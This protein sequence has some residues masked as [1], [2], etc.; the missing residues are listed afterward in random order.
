MWWWRALRSTARGRVDAENETEPAG[1]R[2]DVV[3][4]VRLALFLL[5][6]TSAL[7]GSESPTAYY[8]VE[9]V[10]D[11][12]GVVPKCNGL[13]FLP[14]GR[15][16]AAF[17]HG[18]ICF[19][20]PLSRKWTRYAEGLHTPMGVLAVSVKEI[21]VSQRPELTRLRDTDGDGV[22]DLYECVSDRWELSGN[23]HEFAYG[24]VADGKGGFYVALGS[25]SGE[26]VSRYEMRGH[27]DPAGRLFPGSQPK[28]SMYSFVAYRGWVV[29][30]GPDGGLTPIACGFRQPNGIV[31]DPQGRL[32]VTDNQGD[33]VGTS[34]LH[35]VQAGGFY[36]HPAGLCWEGDW[37]GPPTLE[38]LDRRRREG[39]VLFPHAI[40]A[41]SPGQ[42]AFDTTGGKF[43]PY[44]GQM[45][46]TEFNI[47]RV[48]RVMMEEVGGELQG[49]TAPFYDGPPLRAGCARLAFAPDGSLWVGQT[50]R[51]LGWIGGKGIQRISWK[52]RMPCDVLRMHLTSSGFELTF[53]EP[54]DPVAARRAESYHMRRYYYLYQGDYGSPR[55]DLHDVR[56]SRLAVSADGRRVSFDVDTLQAGYIYELRLPGV[57][58][59]D[60]TP[61]L[62][63][64]LAYTANRLADGSIRPVPRPPVTGGTAGSGQD[65]PHPAK[66][67]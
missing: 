40:L 61:V 46:V 8:S 36:G 44:A 19:Y 65:K 67:G 57:R 25:S 4:A 29:R 38:Q 26:G 39:V 62:N 22:A 21:L 10:P 18:E 63:P 6:A 66:G 50:G 51:E 12:P 16:V 55:V 41:N 17:D 35:Y 23:F 9:D 59:A 2:C 1:E 28:Y 52:G 27:Y 33:W 31:L 58:S 54:V 14:D 60:G 64:L 49:A 13:A 53:T 45:F 3:T 11:P 15:L 47:P 30:I 42:P 24:P 56:L 43:G 5:V 37:H 48:L 20:E 32:F 34:K 7:W